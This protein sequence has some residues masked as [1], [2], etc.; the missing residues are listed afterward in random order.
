[1]L[2]LN[3]SDKY[4]SAVN[5]KIGFGGLFLHRGFLDHWN[6]QK[7]VCNIWQR[8]SCLLDELIEKS[9]KKI[10]FTVAFF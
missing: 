9:A 8:F 1:M 5:K 10:F 4:A 3:V 7:S 2:G 6:S